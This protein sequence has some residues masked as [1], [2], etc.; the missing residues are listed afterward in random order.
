LYKEITMPRLSASFIGLLGVIL[1]TPFVSYAQPAPALD[2]AARAYVVGHPASG[3]ILMSKETDTRLE[4]ASLTKLM[5]LYI[6]FDQLK[7]GNLRLED[8][9]MVSE[10]AWRKGGSKM[11][12]EVG[13]TAKVD[14]LIRGFPSPPVTTR[15]SPWP[16]T[17]P[18]ARRA[19]PR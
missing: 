7:S 12:I 8:D 5:T 19:L 13:K 14:D 11:F 16:S 4:P 6:I 9:V 1:F 18:V 15:A 10:R 3:R 2:V 17:L